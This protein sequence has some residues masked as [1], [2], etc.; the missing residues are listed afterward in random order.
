M[1]VS[2]FGGLWRG[3]ITRSNC[4]CLFGHTR[5]TSVI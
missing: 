2:E 1:A 5:D 3:D 4:I